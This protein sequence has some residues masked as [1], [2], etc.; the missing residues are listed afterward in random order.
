MFKVQCLADFIV[1]HTCYRVTMFI[2]L[3]LDRP[4]MFFM[5]DNLFYIIRP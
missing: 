5:S 3:H 1:N 4:N 2:F